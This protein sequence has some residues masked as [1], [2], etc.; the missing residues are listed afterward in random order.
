MCSLFN[1]AVMYFP[2]ALFAV[3][4]A[5]ETVAGL[6]GNVITNEI[7]SNTV[8]ICR[9]CVFFILTSFNV[10]CFLLLGCDFFKSFFILCVCFY[11]WQ[12]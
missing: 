6:A 4:A 8:S 1:Y 2:G 9:G 3:I 7:Y 11:Y 5:M 12:F 10:V